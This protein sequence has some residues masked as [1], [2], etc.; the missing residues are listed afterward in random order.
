MDLFCGRNQIKRYFQDREARNTEATGVD[1]MAGETDIKADIKEV[2]KFIPPEKQFDVVTDFEGAR[3][4]MNPEIIK[5]YLRGG[6]T[7]Y[8]RV[9]RLVVL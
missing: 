3:G 5:N 8:W 7:F 1:L 9:Q 4:V 6:R 2:E